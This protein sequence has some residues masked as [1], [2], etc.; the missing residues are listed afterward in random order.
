MINPTAE[1]ILGYPILSFESSKVD[2]ETGEKITFSWWVTGQPHREKEEP[3]L[4]IFDEGAD[5]IVYL[6]LFDL[7]EDTLQLRVV[8]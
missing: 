2:W 1:K 3:L 6:E 8:E 5:L 4:D 7:N